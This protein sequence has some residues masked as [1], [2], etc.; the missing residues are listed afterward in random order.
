[1]ANPLL[2]NMSNSLPLYD[3]CSERGAGVLLHITS[4]PSETG[5]GNLGTSAYRFIDF[6]EAS[7][8]KYWQLC[9]LGPTGYGD[10]PYQSFS[11]FA[12]NPYFIDWDP[13]IEAGLISSGELAPLHRLRHDK[14]EYGPLYEHFWDLIQTASRRFW[15]APV[16]ISD[17]SDIEEFQASG[18]ELLEPFAWYKALKNYFGGKIWLEW[19]PAYR[20]Y[21]LARKT[22]IEA[23]GLEESIQDE[24]FY[25]YIFFNQWKRLREYANNRGIQ[26]IGDI[27]IFVSLDSS[28]VWSSP[29]QFQLDPNTLEPTHVAGVPPDYFSADGQLWGNPLF[30]WAKMKKDGYRWWLKRLET[31]FELYDVIRVDHFRGFYDYW[32]VPA[33]SKTARNGK[34]KKGPG[35][36]FFKV[37]KAAFP[38]AR[39]IAEDLG[40]ASEGVNALRDDCGFPGMAVLQ[41]AFD[42][43]NNSLFLPHNHIQ[44]MAVYPGTH[45]N[46]T[47]LG[48]YLRAPEPTRD[49]LRRYFRVSG[50]EIAWDLIRA[51]YSSAAN[52]AIIPLQDLLSLGSEARMNTPSL[53]LGNWQWRYLPAHLDGLQSESSPYL[54]ELSWLYSR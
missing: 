51:S 50:E 47:S 8:F 9:P 21:A 30:D 53:A 38:E 40:E 12:G 14:V 6:L 32:S 20:S 18:A 34:W 29:E 16:Q 24:I 27:P 31:S 26:I 39:I 45:D 3:W 15:K 33:G 7:G 37:V 2:L 42:P 46:D 49:F 41:F 1:M 28:D 11:A 19:D 48:W 52:L 25:Q 44:N 10:S 4:L 23:L 35:L 17:Y 43:G 36:P 13:L 54:Q 5:I 22:G